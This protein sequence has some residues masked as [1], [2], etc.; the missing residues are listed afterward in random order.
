MRGCVVPIRRVTSHR[1][2]GDR[3]KNDPF[4]EQVIGRGAGN[5]SQGFGVS[6][7]GGPFKS[8]YRITFGLCVSLWSANPVTS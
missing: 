3:L 4:C 6:S 2:E 7:A 1:Y 5:L 8:Q